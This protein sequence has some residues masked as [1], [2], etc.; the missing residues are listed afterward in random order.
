M[1]RLVRESPMPWSQQE[2][3]EEPETIVSVPQQEEQPDMAE[4]KFIVDYNL[5]LDYEGSEPKI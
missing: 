2:G 1:A 5:Y 4:G 3:I